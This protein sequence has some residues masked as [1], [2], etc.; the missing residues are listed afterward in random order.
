VTNLRSTLFIFPLTYDGSYLGV[1]VAL[2]L[3]AGV[4]LGAFGSYLGV[5][6]FLTA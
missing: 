2:L 5:R 6:R 1:L 3:A 4:G